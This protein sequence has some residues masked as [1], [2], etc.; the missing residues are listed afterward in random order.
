MRDRL[1]GENT[2]LNANIIEHYKINILSTNILLVHFEKKNICHCTVV[3]RVKFLG[4]Y[5]FGQ[6]FNIKQD[7][8]RESKT[9]DSM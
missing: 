1:C 5:G 9:L 8:L 7:A 2:Q 6:Y 4:D 3:I